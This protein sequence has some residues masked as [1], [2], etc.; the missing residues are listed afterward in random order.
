M[1][2]EEAEIDP[3]SDGASGKKSYRAPALEKGLDVLE[4]LAEE[5]LPLPFPVIVRRLGRSPGELFRVAQVLEARGYVEQV[6][7]GLVLTARMFHQGLSG[8]PI[9]GL[10]EIALPVMRR[11][12]G[13][14]HQSCHLVLPSRGD[15]VVVARMESP[16]QLGFSVRV[17]YRQP[18]YLTGSGAVLYAFQPD[19]IR[20]AWEGMFDPV[21]SKGELD[22]FRERAEAVRSTGH[23]LQPSAIAEGIMDISAPIMRGA[24]AAAALA[25]P[26]LQPKP[27]REWLSVAEIVSMLIVATQDISN[28]MVVGDSRA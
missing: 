26:F 25:I 23:T 4:L 22:Q 24:R 28:Q 7:S 27:R 3:S 16:E 13:S 15:M 6:P 11:L 8:P 19:D 10:V 2:L 9:R 5:G 1:E 18:L 14:T 17:G 20:A 21:P 12:A